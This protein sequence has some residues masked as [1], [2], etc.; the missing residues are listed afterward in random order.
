MFFVKKILK[1]GE[2]LLLKNCHKA[3]LWLVYIHLEYLGRL[4]YSHEVYINNDLA[5][6]TIEVTNLLLAAVKQQISCCMKI[7]VDL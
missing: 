7:C 2:I 3:L 5:S 4:Q 1:S 6:M